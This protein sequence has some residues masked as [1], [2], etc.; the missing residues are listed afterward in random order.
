MVWRALTPWANVVWDI[1]MSADKH[2]KKVTCEGVL[3]T[4]CAG[5]LALEKQSEIWLSVESYRLK[6]DSGNTVRRQHVEICA[7]VTNWEKGEGRDKFDAVSTISQ[8]DV[9]S[10]HAGRRSEGH[11]SWKTAHRLL[12]NAYATRRTSHIFEHLGIGTWQ[13]AGCQYRTKSSGVAAVGDEL[14]G[15]G[16][17]SWWCFCWWCRVGAGSCVGFFNR[18]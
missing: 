2:E 1:I 18:R 14:K 13:R 17:S 6:E 11:L 5:H 16:S 12:R 3:F 15:S 10:L 7:K 9:K 8:T 4:T